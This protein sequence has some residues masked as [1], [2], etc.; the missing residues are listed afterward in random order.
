MKKVLSF[1]LVL[2]LILAVAMPAFAAICPV[3][4]MAEVLTEE[5]L[6]QLIQMLA[7]YGNKTIQIVTV[8]SLEGENIEVYA[9]NCAENTGVGVLCVVAVQERKWCITT[10]PAYEGAID[11]DVIDLIGAECV[12]YLTEGDYYGAFTVFAEECGYYLDGYVPGEPDDDLDDQG[13]GGFGRFLIC[14]VIGLAVGGITAGIMAGKNKSVR[15][16]HSAADYVRSGSMNVN[17]S[18]D[19]YLYH[20]V[21]RTP[22]PQNTGSHGGG[23]GSR[24]TRSGSF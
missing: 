1:F 3:A 6:R 23:G 14:L 21:T 18:R 5:E 16:R 7:P 19:I 4:D 22:K 2:L 10:S 9:E 24:S 13:V 11:G 15:P 12:P 17:V 8:E 20:H